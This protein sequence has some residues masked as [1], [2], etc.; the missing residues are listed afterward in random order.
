M[1]RI[2]LLLGFIAF[3]AAGASAQTFP[4]TGATDNN[5]STAGNWASGTVPPSASA[6]I[7]RFAP[8]TGTLTSMV[9]EWM[10]ALM[11]G[12]MLLL[13]AAPMRARRYSA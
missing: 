12:L 1:R 7:I 2:R 3:A 11:A 10:L 5:W 13:G 4:W 6:S 8:S 9:S